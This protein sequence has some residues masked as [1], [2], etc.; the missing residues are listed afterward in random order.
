MQGSRSIFINVR[1][2][3]MKFTL[4]EVER[5]EVEKCI[6][7]LRKIGFHKY[8]DVLSLAGLGYDDLF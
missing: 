7:S 4:S 3:H 8:G 6:S 2:D 5:S 1:Q